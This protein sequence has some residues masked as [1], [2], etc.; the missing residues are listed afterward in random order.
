MKANVGTAR[1]LTWLI[2]G[3]CQAII[4]QVN[5]KYILPI[6]SVISLTCYMGIK[7]FRENIHGK[8]RAPSS[9]F[10]LVFSNNETSRQLEHIILEVTHNSNTNGYHQLKVFPCSIPLQIIT[11]PVV[12][13]NTTP[14]VHSAVIKKCFANNDKFHQATRSFFVLYLTRVLLNNPISPLIDQN[15][16]ESN[17]LKVL[18]IEYPDLIGFHPKLSISSTT[19]EIILVSQASTKNSTQLN[20]TTLRTHLG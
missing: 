3:T 15:D 5:G 14:T 13:G 19:P 12:E 17:I 9:V 7:R 11:I 18:Q 1:N 2:Y 20:A 16:N 6:H 8:D 10:S 4:G